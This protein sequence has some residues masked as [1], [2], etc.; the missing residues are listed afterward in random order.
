M[1][2]EQTYMAGVMMEKLTATG[3]ESGAQPQTLTPFHYKA[4]VQVSTLTYFVTCHINAGL[5][6]DQ[7]ISVLILIDR[8]CTCSSKQGQPLFITSYTA[9]R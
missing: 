7:A 8:L 4:P 5:S 9:H 2:F 3:D 6:D 1:G